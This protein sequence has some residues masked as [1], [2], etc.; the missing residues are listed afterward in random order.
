MYIKLID[1]KTATC[2]KHAVVIHTTKAGAEE[3]KNYYCAECYMRWMGWEPKIKFEKTM[4]DLLDYWRHEISQNK[5][6][7]MR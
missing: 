1:C 6:F 5:K 4:K 2:E 3:Y 7:L